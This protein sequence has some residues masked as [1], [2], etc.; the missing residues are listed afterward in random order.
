M[1]F[2]RCFASEY[3]YNEKM[4]LNKFGPLLWSQTGGLAKICI[5]EQY[6]FINQILKIKSLELYKWTE[7]LF[8]PTKGVRQCMQ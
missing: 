5:Q 2:K 8:F 4:Y 3:K 7:L 6:T 1:K